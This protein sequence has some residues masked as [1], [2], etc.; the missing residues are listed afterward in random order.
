MKTIVINNQKGG[1]GKT[2]LAVHLAWYL[3]EQ[4]MDD[5]KEAKVLFIDLDGQGNGGTALENERQSGNSADLF[6]AT[7]QLPLP[8][9]S[10]ISVMSQDA[11]LHSVEMS[12]VPQ[13]IRKFRSFQNE[14]GGY[15]YC[16]VDTPPTWGARNFTALAITDFLISPVEMKEFALGG[17]KNL[18]ASVE[19]VETRAREGRKVANLGFLPSRFN[20][21]SAEER[22]KLQATL[23]AVGTKL[24][25]PGV[26]KLRDSYEIALANRV[27]VWK[28][29]SSSGAKVAA[30]EIKQILKTIASRMEPAK[31]EEM[32]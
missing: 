27:P 22:Q 3:A 32:A 18:L 31:V 15:D 19:A 21:H 20:S 9:G 4:M 7:R 2:M 16:V 28:L 24:M 26:I 8:V 30:A 25:F 23:D 13:A 17:I 12:S 6:E 5:G 29:P 1:V 14:K 10:G 11:R